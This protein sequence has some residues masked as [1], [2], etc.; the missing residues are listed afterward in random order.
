MRIP[1]AITISRTLGSGG[2]RIGLLVARHLGWPFCDRR[3]LRHAAQTIGISLATLRQ[4][5]ELPFGFFDC[6]LTLTAFASPEASYAPPFDMPIY[7]HDLF[8]IEGDV[9]RRLVVHEPAVL[10]GRG[11]F[12]VLK[13]R[14][15]TL[16]VRIQAAL[17]YRVHHLLETG[18]YLDGEAAQ[19]A[20]EASDRNR[21]AFYRRV[22]GV[23][24]N[25]PRHF[26]LVLNPENAGPECCADDVVSE[27]RA[28][29]RDR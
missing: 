6:L 4:Q 27:A 10:V 18:K 24:W 1:P 14:P 23:D 12:L 17:P 13:D 2:T 16:H 25:D 9:L 3:I 28:R 21:T 19:E 15:S 20:I 8:K 26:H 22:S 29:F 5:E 7:S 11:G